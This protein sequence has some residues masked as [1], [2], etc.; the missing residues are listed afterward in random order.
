MS[1]NVSFRPRELHTAAI[2]GYLAGTWKADPA[3]SEIAFAVRQLMVA[4][5]AAEVFDPDVR[6]GTPLPVDAAGRERSRRCG[7]FSFGRIPTCTSRSRT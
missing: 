5:R 3:S 6:I 4:R 1:D 2:P 7:R